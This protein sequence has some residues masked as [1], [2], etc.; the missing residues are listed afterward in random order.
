VHDVDAVAPE[1]RQDFFLGAVLKRSAGSR[2]ECIDAE[3][4]DHA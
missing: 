2:L 4:E 1:H 3:L